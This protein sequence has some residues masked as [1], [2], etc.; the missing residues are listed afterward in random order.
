MKSQKSETVVITS[1]TETRSDF[2]QL[3]SNVFDFILGNWSDLSVLLP[4]VR[5]RIPSM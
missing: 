3:Y 4:N 2:K 5:S 1:R